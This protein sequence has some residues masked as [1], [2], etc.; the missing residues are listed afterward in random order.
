MTISSVDSAL[1]RPTRHAVG[2]EG[3]RTIIHERTTIGRKLC[4]AADRRPASQSSTDNSAVA[5][6]AR[7]RKFTT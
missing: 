1:R 7:E 4:P 3:V 5:F 2:V 6:A